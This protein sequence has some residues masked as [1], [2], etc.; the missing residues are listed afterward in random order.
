MHWG[1][2]VP[3]VS[4]RIASLSDVEPICRFGAAHIADHYR[5]LIGSEAAEA[6]VDKWWNPDR[7]A[8]AVERGQMTVAV[9][10]DQLIGVAEQGEYAGSH[11]IWKLYLHPHFRGSGLGPGLLRHIIDRLPADAVSLQV[12]HFEANTRAGE[13]Y[14]R[15]GFEYLRTEPHPVNPAMNTVWRELKLDRV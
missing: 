11:V 12:E 13:F 1:E 8:H 6:Q 2:P 14:E 15:E 5:P 4:I 9:S 3:E 10:G 7:I